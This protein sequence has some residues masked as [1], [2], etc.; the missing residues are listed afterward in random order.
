MTE[1]IDVQDAGDGVSKLVL[2]RGP[3]NALTPAFLDEIE[4]EIA[5]LAQ[6]DNVRAILIASAFRTFSAGMDLKEASAFDTESQSAVVDAL[7]RCYLTL[8]SCL[9]P[10][11]CAVSGG[12]IAGGLFFVLASDHR[13]ATPDAS[14]GLAEV[15]VGVNFPVVALEIARAMLAPND[16]RRLMQSGQPYRCAQAAEA[17]IVDVV[18]GPEE[19]QQEA[20]AAARRLARL[21]AQAYAQVKAQIRGA[22]SADMAAALPENRN[23]WFNDETRAA[24]ARV[25]EGQ[26]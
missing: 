20:L 14:F 8:Y 6:D 17:G 2:Q 1:W 4:A 16:L 19:L 5:R 22:L 7:N 26:G 15:R 12:A 18:V 11:V 23:S 13:V 24:M 9:K 3:V 10:V 21:P 25:L